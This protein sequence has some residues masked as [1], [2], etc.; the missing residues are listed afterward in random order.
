[1]SNNGPYRGK[2]EAGTKIAERDQMDAAVSAWLRQGPS[3]ISGIME[4]GCIPSK[5]RSRKRVMQSLQRMRKQ[6]LVSYTRST[7]RWALINV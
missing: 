1:M 3:S 4:S 6:G 2:P 5:W 7:Q